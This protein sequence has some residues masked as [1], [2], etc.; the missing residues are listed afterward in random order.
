MDGAGATTEQLA[1]PASGA[2]L[3]GSHLHWLGPRPALCRVNGVSRTQKRFRP[4]PPFVSRVA[5]PSVLAAEVSLLLHAG[6]SFQALLRLRCADTPARRGLSQTQKSQHSDLSWAAGS[7]PL[8]NVQTR[9]YS[10][11]DVLFLRNTHLDKS[12]IPFGFPWCNL[13]VEKRGLSPGLAPC[14]SV[15]LPQRQAQPSCHHFA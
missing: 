11:C 9:N 15:W 10:Q 7:P 14:G 3:E 1:A 6:F 12:P 8:P 2:S 5:P 4:Q 13:G